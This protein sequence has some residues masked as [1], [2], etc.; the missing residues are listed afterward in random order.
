M[1]NAINFSM[2]VV[3]DGNGLVNYEA[4]AHKF[5]TE[6]KAWDSVYKADVPTIT[7]AI[8]SVYDRFNVIRLNKPAL[9][10]YV[11]AELNVSPDSHKEISSRVESVLKNDPAFETTKGKNGG[12]TRVQKLHVEPSD[13]AAVSVH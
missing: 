12:I 10:T 2:Y 6:L 8:H 7:A 5:L 9:M 11:L 4:T 13:T 1:S 3:R